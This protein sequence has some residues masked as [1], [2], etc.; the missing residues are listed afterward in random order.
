MLRQVQKIIEYERRKKACA[1]THENT[2]I[3]ESLHD[4]LQ[5]KEFDPYMLTPKK[6]EHTIIEMAEDEEALL[7]VLF[8]KHGGTFVQQWGQQ[9]IGLQAHPARMAV[10]GNHHQRC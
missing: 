7:F 10:L 3:I 1:H 5:T 6:G 4:L 8:S 2:S 9:V